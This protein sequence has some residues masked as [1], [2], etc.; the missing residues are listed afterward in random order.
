MSCIVQTQA[1]SEINS[2]T[3][4]GYNFPENRLW[5]SCTFVQNR[6]WCFGGSNSTKTPVYSLNA[7]NDWVQHDNTTTNDT[8]YRQSQQKMF[9]NKCL[10]ALTKPK[11]A[12]FEYKLFLKK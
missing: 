3:N 6:I 9:T 1:I 11:V 2:W 8:E 10:G 12:L 4:I 7:T 5:K